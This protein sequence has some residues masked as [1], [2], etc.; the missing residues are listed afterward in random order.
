MTTSLPIRTTMLHATVAVTCLLAAAPAG[1]QLL[2]EDHF[3]TG[4]V[5][6][7]WVSIGNSQWVQ[8][9]WLH[10]RDNDGPPRDAGAL[11]HDGDKAWTDYQLYIRANFVQSGP[12][13]YDNFAILLRTDGYWRQPGHMAGSAYEFEFTGPRWSPDLANTI[14]LA[15]L[16]DGKAEVL[17]LVSW[18]LQSL[19]AAPIIADVRGDHIRL[20]IGFE[21]VF[22]V[23]DPN[24]LTYG[25]VGVHTI[26]ETESR[27]DDVKVWAVPEPQTW[28]MML[29]GMAAFGVFMR[30]RRRT[31]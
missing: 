13:P 2:F 27:F 9:G 20:W 4:S 19:D 16:V 25:G 5:S 15:R 24:P 3:D 26:W 8:D 18:N 11:V 10:V 1:A 28:A 7:A 31:E 21:K 29:G 17:G 23:V 30:G 12:M 14:Q 6:P 22:D